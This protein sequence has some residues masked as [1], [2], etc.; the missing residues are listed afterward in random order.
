MNSY[1]EGLPIY[2]AAM[3]SVVL[4]DRVVRVFPR[5]H[6]YTLGQRLREVSLDALVWVQR[7]NTKATRV[8]ALPRLCGRTEELKLLVQTGKEL[9][10]FSSF[11]Q[12]AQ[13]MEQV[14]NFARQAEAWR[15]HDNKLHQQRPEPSR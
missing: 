4:I 6:K 10:A 8:A 15:A 5:H 9:Q 11:Q 7:A 13:V 14:V 3:D 2:R 1:Y 12:Y